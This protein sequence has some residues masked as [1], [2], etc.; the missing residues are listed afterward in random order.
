MVCEFQFGKPV[1]G[2]FTSDVNK[3]TKPE[4]ATKAAEIKKVRLGVPFLFCYQLSVIGK[5]LGDD[6]HLAG[7]G[8]AYGF[9]GITLGH[10]YHVTTLQV[11]LGLEA[12]KGF[13]R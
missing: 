5:P 4:T 6:Q 7:V 9:H 13:F 12:F 2:R 8:A 1:P 11:S 10:E 3:I